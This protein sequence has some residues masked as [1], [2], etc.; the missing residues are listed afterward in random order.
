MIT[1]TGCAS[2]VPLQPAEDANNPA[3]AEVMV[4]LP[5]EVAGQ[6]QRYTN[7]Q[8]TSAWGNPASILL[9]C[10]IQPTGPT[11]LPCVTLNGVDWI[12]DDSRAPLY[13]FEAYGRS[14]GLE[15]IIDDNAEPP[16][17]GTTALMDLSNAVA[18]LPQTRKCTTVEEL[19]IDD[20]Q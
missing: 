19:N 15:V 1:L 17:S 4:R 20:A 2:E 16:V 9:Y 11:D 13:R 14:P 5:D 6:Q 18:E 8:A 3:C 12:R 10:G 7:A